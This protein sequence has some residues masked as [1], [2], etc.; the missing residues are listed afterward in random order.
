MCAFCHRYARD[1]KRVPG[2]QPNIDCQ[3]EHLFSLGASIGSTY[4]RLSIAPS[5]TTNNKDAL[6]C[7][8]AQPRQLS[9]APC[10]TLG[11]WWPRC[12]SSHQRERRRCVHPKLRQGVETRRGPSALAELCYSIFCQF[13]VGPVKKHEVHCE[14]GSR[15]KASTVDD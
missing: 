15:R 12:C 3:D 5:C 11:L 7:M 13:S 9:L 8:G 2:L 4:Q 14:E 1:L 6:A 10:G